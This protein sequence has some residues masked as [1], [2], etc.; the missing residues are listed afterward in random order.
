MK[1]QSYILKRIPKF[2]SI[3][4]YKTLTKDELISIIRGYCYKYEYILKNQRDF[5]TRIEYLNRRNDL[6]NKR[7]YYLMKKF[8]NTSNFKYIDKLIKNIQ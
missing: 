3:E 6:L 7:L 5:I 1:T 2:Q 4:Y 8:N